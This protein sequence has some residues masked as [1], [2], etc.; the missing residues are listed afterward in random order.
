MKGFLEQVLTPGLAYR[1]DDAGKGRWSKGLKG[2]S[3]RLIVT[4]DMPAFVFRWYF[5]AHSLKSLKRNILGFCGD[6]THPHHVAGWHRERSA[7]A[8][9][10]A[11][12]REA[13]DLGRRAA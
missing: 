11:G 13:R 10:S 7:T 5:G 6:R 12:S 9:A 4:M 2:K 1:T 8:D 3:A